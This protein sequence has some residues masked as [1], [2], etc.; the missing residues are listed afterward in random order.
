MSDDQKNGNEDGIYRLDTLPPPDG[1][2][3]AYSAPTR[4]G[5]MA[6]AAVEEL[7]KAAERRATDLSARSEEKRRLAGAPAQ[8]PA[9]SQ[10]SSSRLGSA[11]PASSQ[12][13][14]PAS[15]RLGSANPAS[16]PK[17]ARRPVD[18]P[19][20]P[21]MPRGLAPRPAAPPTPAF[22]A[23]PLPAG[24]RAP[25]PPAD[26]QGPHPSAMP[27]LYAGPGDEAD[28]DQD[29]RTLLNQNAPPPIVGPRPAPA[30]P[31]PPAAAPPVAAP[32]VAF[33]TP[34]PPALPPMRPQLHTDP[35][36]GALAGPAMASPASPSA[37][38]Q[39]PAAAPP[40]SLAPTAPAQPRMKHAALV[41]VAILFAVALALYLLARC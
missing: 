32:Q 18:V 24:A 36:G 20:P 17:P 34:T 27:R 29:E 28:G 2:T 15:S 25:A 10:P 33:A 13:S 39:P 35:M 8:P 19:R 22:P 23:P 12:S 41:I 37:L 7:M 1:E 26:V 40:F 6:A 11:Q 31:A 4:V 9:S 38:A 3:D 30:V 16:S 21:P 5:P 14:Q